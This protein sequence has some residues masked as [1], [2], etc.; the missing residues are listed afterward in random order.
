MKND[1]KI[2]TSL[3]RQAAMRIIFY[4]F[5][6]AGASLFLFLDTGRQWHPEMNVIGEISYRELSQELLLMV[7]AVLFWDLAGWARPGEVIWNT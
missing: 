3:L 7:F 2:G 1:H 6:V 5:L 4:A